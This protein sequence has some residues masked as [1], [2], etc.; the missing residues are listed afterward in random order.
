MDPIVETALAY[1]KAE[2][3]ECA[4]LADLESVRSDVLDNSARIDFV[5]EQGRSIM[6]AISHIEPVLDTASG[7]ADRFT[8]IENE[9]RRI[10]EVL[11]DVQMMLRT[12][13][14]DDMSKR[15]SDLDMLFL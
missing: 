13:G 6:G 1:T 8:H 7:L 10:K 4:R 3:S 15:V 11:V 12:L 14:L 2:L 9:V 5:E